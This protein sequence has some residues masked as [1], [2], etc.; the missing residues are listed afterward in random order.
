MT[1]SH[2]NARPILSIHVGSALHQP[3]SQRPSH[4]AR[5]READ[6]IAKCDKKLPAEG[7]DRIAHPAFHSV[8][9]GLR[10]VQFV[11]QELAGR[12]IDPYPASYDDERSQGNRTRHRPRLPAE[13]SK[14]RSR[15]ANSQDQLRDRS[16][17]KMGRQHREHVLDGIVR[18]DWVPPPRD[19]A[20]PIQA[21]D[22][23]RH[24]QPQR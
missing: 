21:I 20:E 2:P 17:G 16:R 24:Q 7:I 8:T 18:I 6:P 12:R 11:F 23:E 19:E 9:V 14:R 4:C 15:A 13:A 3:A 1:Q 10:E 5:H 22:S